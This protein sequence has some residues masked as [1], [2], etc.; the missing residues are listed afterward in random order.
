MGMIGMSDVER[1]ILMNQAAIMWFLHGAFLCE[2]TQNNV[3]SYANMFDCFK[4]TQVMLNA[5]GGNMNGCIY[6]TDSG[7]CEK[8]SNGVCKSFCVL[9]DAPCGYKTPSNGDKIR[10]MSDE[11]LVDLLIENDCPVDECKYE[12]EYGNVSRNKCRYCW[13]EWLS[14]EA[15]HE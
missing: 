13:L 11:E 14:K 12:D 5:D 3:K 9:P 8:F 2:V 10:A 6:R 4:M 15:E 7:R 1:Q